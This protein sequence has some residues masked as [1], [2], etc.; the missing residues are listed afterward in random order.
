MTFMNRC[1]FAIGTSGQLFQA[2]QAVVGESMVAQFEVDPGPPHP[3]GEGKDG[4]EVGLL[5]RGG[6]KVGALQAVAP[7]RVIYAGTTS[8]TL[9]PGIRLAWLVVPP[10]WVERI[11]N[12]KRVADHHSTALT[13]MIVADLLLSGAYDQHT[14]ATAVTST[15]CAVNSSGR[16][17]PRLRPRHGS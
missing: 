2:L 14:Y 10:D 17:W 15:A 16:S 11:T 13:Q 9:A 3:G 5:A 1:A 7:H 6:Q 12:A 4:G 8:R